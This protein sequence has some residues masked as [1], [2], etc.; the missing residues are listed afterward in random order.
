MAR[1]ATLYLD[2]WSDYVCPFC[3]LELPVLNEFREIYGDSVEVRWHA[4]ELRPEPVALPEADDESVID[5]WEDNIYPMATERMLTMRLPSINTRSR[6]ALEAARFS[7]EAGAF[8]VM[9]QALFKAYFEDSLDIGD[10]D[11]LIDIGSTV[12][13]DPEALDEALREDRFAASV[14]EDEDFAKQLGITSVPFIVLS[15]DAAP[16]QEAPPPPIALRGAAPIE[17][18]EAAVHRLFPDGF[19]GD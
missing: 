8:D 6:K 1:G 9:H 12:G 11:V 15:R 19:P 18:F 4:F 5:S 7:Q 13:L 14:Q 3:Y 17:H 16:D 2:V 10:T